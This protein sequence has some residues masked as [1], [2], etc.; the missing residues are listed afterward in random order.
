M[1][2]VDRIVNNTLSG[3]RPPNSSPVRNSRSVERVVYNHTIKNEKGDGGDSYNK[4]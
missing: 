3:R 2:R 4:L 1:K